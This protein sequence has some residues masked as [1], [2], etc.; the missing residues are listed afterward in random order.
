MKQGPCI[1]LASGKFF[2]LNDFDP[3]EIHIEDIAAHLSKLCRFTGA[4]RR[5]YSVAQHSVL[6]SEIVAAPNALAGL[7]H[8]ATEAYIND[9]SRPVKRLCQAYVDYERNVLWPAVAER[10]GLP[11]ILPPAIHTTDDIVLITEKR[12]LM[13]PIAPEDAHVWA[14]ADGIAPLRASIA[15]LGPDQAEAAFRRRWHQLTG[16]KI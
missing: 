8:D 15:P 7:L 4:T 6:V 5:F 1:Q 2:F 12:D 14:W 16:E 3:S 10:F 9:M 13:P 11:Q